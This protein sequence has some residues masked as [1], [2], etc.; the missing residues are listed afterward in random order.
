MFTTS[1]QTDVMEM[2]NEFVARKTLPDFYKKLGCATVPHPE[3]ITN[4]D[5]T[6]Y[7]RRVLGYDF[8]IAK[9]GLDPDKVL[10]SAKKNLFALKY[11]E[12]ETTAMQA[13]LDGGLDSFKGANGKKIG[14]AQLNKIVAMCRKGVST[15]TI[16]NYLKNEG[17]IK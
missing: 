9:L 7:N 10:A 15:E 8:V 2:M 11:T 17:I 4:K 16:E 1:T 6:G 13:L 14:K 5:S 3:Y 12:Q